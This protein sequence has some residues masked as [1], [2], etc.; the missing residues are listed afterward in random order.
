MNTPRKPVFVCDILA[1]LESV[2][3]I[4]MASGNDNVGLLVGRIDGAVNRILVALDASMA[5]IQE[6]IE[7]QAELIVTHHPVNRGVTNI[8]F[9]PVNGTYD[10]ARMYLM[11]ENKIA[12]ICMHTNLDAAD[13]GVNDILAERCRLRET[14]ALCDT[15]RLGRVGYADGGMSAREYAAQVSKALG[16]K[17]LRYCDS[18]RP[19]RK[20]AV[21]SGNSTDDYQR[22]VS[23]G[24]D[25]F[26]TG[27][28][29]YHLWVEAGE[30]GITLIDAGHYE[31]EVIVCESLR[32]LMA[33]RFPTLDVAVSE[34]MCLPYHTV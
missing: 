28:V 9:C 4:D 2:A 11:A 30:N 31:T 20:V 13:G 19:V 18:G 22:A 10:G 17:D 23:A 16:C 12:C 3:P 1:A 34:C 15:T 8:A 33:E 14:V 32:R 24:C 5:V 21:G 25:T 29:R 6:A 7:R 27:D 26:V